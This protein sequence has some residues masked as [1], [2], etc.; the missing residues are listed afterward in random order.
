MLPNFAIL[1]HMFSLYAFSIASNS[2]CYYPNGDV[3]IDHTPCNSRAANSA[4]C[5]AY[6]LCLENSYCFNRVGRMTRSSCTDSGWNSSACPYFCRDGDSPF[7]HGTVAASSLLFGLSSWDWVKRWW[8]TVYSSS[9]IGLSSVIIS[10]TSGVLFCC[11]MGYDEATG[12]CSS[13]T[14]QVEHRP[15]TLPESVVIFNRTSGSTTFPAALP[16]QSQFTAVATATRHELTVGLSVGLPL[17]TATLAALG[18]FYRERRLRLILANSPTGSG[19]QCPTTVLVSMGTNKIFEFDGTPVVKELA[20]SYMSEVREKGFE[21][22][23]FRG[24]NMVFL[25]IFRL[26]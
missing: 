6:D 13:R 2:T 23:W 19:L 1:L 5:S 21:V 8:S 22:I 15:F 18:M 11:G 25:L 17:L 12:N 16:A 24:G 3:A 20:A 26:R 7:L 9:D 4:C 14:R 10:N